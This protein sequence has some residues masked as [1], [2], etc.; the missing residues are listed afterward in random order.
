MT[1]SVKWKEDLHALV[2]G[3]SKLVE[4]S[5]HNRD[6]TRELMPHLKN[7]FDDESIWIEGLGIILETMKGGNFVDAMTFIPAE[8]AYSGLMDKNMLEFVQFKGR[9]NPKSMHQYLKYMHHIF[10]KQEEQIKLHMLH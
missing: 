8:Y 10:R 3:K 4:L 7:S 9:K 1:S 5:S 6:L 2:A